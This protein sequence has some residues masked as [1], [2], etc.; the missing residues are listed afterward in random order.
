MKTTMDA[1]E[2]EKARAKAIQGRLLDFL[3]E[4]AAAGV[5]VD[6]ALTEKLQQ[7][8]AN[9]EEL[10]VAIIGGFSEGKTSIAA[11]WL[12]K[13]DKSSMH[14]NHEE[15]SNAVVIYEVDGG[16]TLI[17]TPGLFGYK[18]K[19]N[20]DIN[21]QE[22]YKDITKKHVSEA[23]VVLYVMD[24]ANPIKDSHKDDLLWL[25]RDL[26]LLPRTVFV[27]SRFDEV[28]DVA[29]EEDYHRN[30]I[31]KKG[32]VISRLKDLIG[33][34]G[35]EAQALSVVA[36]SANPFDEGVE[37]WLG[38]PARFYQLSHI[39]FL[40]QATTEKIKSNGGQ[41]RLAL[42]TGKS[43]IQDV[44]MREVPVAVERDESLADEVNKLA[45]SMD[46]AKKDADLA[47]RKVTDTQ[48]AL[49]EFVLDHFTD[50]ILQL[51]G[52]DIGTISEF[53]EREIGDGGVVLDTKI[54]NAFS[55]RVN[56]ISSELVKIQTS[57]DSDVN[58]FNS[59][60]TTLGRQ[61]LDYIVK[62]NIINA[63]TVKAARDVVWSSFKFKP[64]GAIKLA[65]GLNGALSVLG[66][67]FELW[68]S[69][70]EGERNDAFVKAKKRMKQDLEGQR[71]ELLEKI[72]ASNFSVEFFPDFERLKQQAAL[73]AD[74]LKKAQQRRESFA[75]WRE[76]AE[77]INA[78]F[79]LM[80]G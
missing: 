74:V 4:G 8:I 68:D 9:N 73:L 16:M 76:N 51:D 79:N 80:K 49:R 32:N 20:A 17:D 40:Q 41:E 24:S 60:V 77:S 54:Q 31:I 28:S 30:L 18:E 14:I 47:T 29:D 34:D 50:L 56:A 70:K 33:L 64:W 10:K 3:K 43:I 26:N 59:H 72:N 42:E 25:F 22:K 11:A 66:V 52:A 44:L 6:P 1:F 45:K 37:H 36:V 62:S 21:A 57:L 58:A 55:R 75:R 46:R 2:T 15:S 38:E 71:K 78:D 61:G 19:F 53:V 39:A 65:K 67:G 7:S 63:N 27:L 12:G 69:W 13:L 23:H 48:I 5:S 35:G